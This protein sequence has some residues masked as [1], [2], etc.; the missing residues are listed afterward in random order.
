MIYPLPNKLSFEI[1]VPEI[2]DVLRVTDDL[3]GV[4]VFVGGNVENR[5]YCFHFRDVFGYRNFDESD[6]FEYWD[7]FGGVLRC[8]CYKAEKS[9]FLDWIR[10]QSVHGEYPDGLLH[11]IVVS[12]DDVIDIAAYDPPDFS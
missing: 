2:F 10:K 8:G 3:H 4:K 6:R 5:E 9:E 11:F 12:S 7:S 1:K